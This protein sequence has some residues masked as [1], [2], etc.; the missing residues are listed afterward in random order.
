MSSLFNDLI[1]SYHCS[2]YIFTKSVSIAS[3]RLIN[4]VCCLSSNGSLLRIPEA[5]NR[6]SNNLVRV[7]TEMCRGCFICS[8]SLRSNSSLI[9]GLLGVMVSS[10]RVRYSK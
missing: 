1:S 2:I 9:N 4:G 3:L 5:T 10:Y 8:M 6:L 7:F